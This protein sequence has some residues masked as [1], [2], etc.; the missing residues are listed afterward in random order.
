VWNVYRAWEFLGKACTIYCYWRCT[1]IHCGYLTCDVSGFRRGALA[2]EKPPPIV[3]VEKAGN[4]GGG[5]GEGLYDAIMIASTA[6]QH[7]EHRVWGDLPRRRHMCHPLTHSSLQLATVTSDGLHTTKTV[8]INAR[9]QKR[10][11]EA[12]ALSEA[13]LTHP[14]SF[15]H[16]IIAKLSM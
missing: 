12:S 6:V 8:G 11:L 3:A 5:E 13:A 10:L 4:E 2:S 16:S 7:W 14:Q 9:C 1:N 15:K